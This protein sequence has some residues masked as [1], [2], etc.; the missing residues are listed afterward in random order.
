[1]SLTRVMIPSA[2]ADSEAGAEE[3]AGG[4]GEAEG[5]ALHPDTGTRGE[6]LPE[7]GTL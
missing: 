6:E 4:Q 3:E 5:G 7:A 2:A 1:M